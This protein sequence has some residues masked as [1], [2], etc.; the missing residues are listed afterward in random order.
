MKPKHDRVQ[1]ATMLRKLY[2][3]H[4][5]SNEMHRTCSKQHSILRKIGEAVENDI[6]SHFE[7]DSTR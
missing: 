7:E 3:L 1:G 6:T 5:E 4:R 2:D